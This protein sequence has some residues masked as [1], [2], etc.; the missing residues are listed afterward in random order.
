MNTKA[1][2]LFIVS[3]FISINCF[4]QDDSIYF[5]QE[6]IVIDECAKAF[7]KNKCLSLKIEEIIRNLLE[8]LFKKRNQEID[9]LKTSVTFELND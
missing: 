3:I 9:T 8:D 6:E 7:D 2:F 1:S 5:P 4:S